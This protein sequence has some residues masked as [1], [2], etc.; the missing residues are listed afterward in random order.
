MYGPT[1]AR[2]DSLFNIALYAEHFAALARMMIEA[3][4]A[5]AIHAFG[6]ALQD[7]EIQRRRPDEADKAA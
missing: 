4:P 3:D 6:D 5:A 1:E 7:A 2:G